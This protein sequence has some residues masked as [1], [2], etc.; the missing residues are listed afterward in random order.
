MSYN[1]DTH[2]WTATQIVVPETPQ[3][4]DVEGSPSDYQTPVNT[5]LSA[6]SPIAPTQVAG[7][8]T[9]GDDDFMGSIIEDDMGDLGY[10]Q[11]ESQ[12]LDSQGDEV[13]P[14]YEGGHGQGDYGY[15]EG[16]GY[17]GEGDDMV[18]KDDEEEEEDAEH[19]EKDLSLLKL[20][21]AIEKLDAR[22]DTTMARM[23]AR[24]ARMELKMDRLLHAQGL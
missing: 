1:M 3:T 13:E 24:M 21:D 9:T 10:S 15:G 22:M 17:G 2:Y 12:P 8:A 5:E 4:Y 6:Y 19:K 20:M 11:P 14:S 7:D 18:A 23:D 16:E